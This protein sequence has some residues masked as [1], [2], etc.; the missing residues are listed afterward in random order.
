MLVV[1]R[2]RLG[3][4]RSKSANAL[5]N[6]AR[7]NRSMRI[8]ERR[9]K[10]ANAVGQRFGVREHMKRESIMALLD[11]FRCLAYSSCTR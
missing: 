6:A 10:S 3:E 7:R 8:G 1:P 2:W 9:S 5:A 4:R 11:P